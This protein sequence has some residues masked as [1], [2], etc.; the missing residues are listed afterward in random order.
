MKYLKYFEKGNYSIGEYLLL[1]GQKFQGNTDLPVE[2]IN[3]LYGDNYVIK[4]DDGSTNV[5][6]KSYIKKTLT[7]KEYT[8]IIKAKK[9]NLI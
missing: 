3:I 5:I 1:N 8:A 2:I 7:K 4:Y 6:D 9:Y